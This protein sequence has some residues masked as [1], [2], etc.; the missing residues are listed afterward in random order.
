MRT[1]QDHRTI[2]CSQQVRQR[3]EQQIK[4]IEEY[5]YAADPQTGWRFYKEWWGNLQ[6][7][8]SGSR[9]NLQAASSSPSTWDQTQ[10]KTSDWNSQHS[11]SLTSG[12]FSH[13]QDGKCELYTHKYSTCRVAQHDYI[14]SRE[15]AWL[16]SCKGSGLHIFV[17]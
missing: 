8:E 13:G 4:N 11:S 15:H 6:T 14:S 2:S 3:K 16:K 17:S 5:D 7:S 9:A 12:V 10:W 1:Q